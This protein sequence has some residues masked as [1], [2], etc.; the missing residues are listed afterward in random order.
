MQMVYA[1]GPMIIVLKKFTKQFAIIVYFVN[2]HARMGPV[3]K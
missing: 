2:V 1:G 3:K